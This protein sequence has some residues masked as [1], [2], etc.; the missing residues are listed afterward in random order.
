VRGTLI[1]LR[2]P[3]AAIAIVAV[4]L[5]GVARP[6]RAEEVAASET[7]LPA[8]TRAWLSVPDIRALRQRFD[9]SP[10]GQLLNDPAMAAFVEHVKAEINSNGKQRLA[11]LGLTLEDLEPIPGGEV[12]I[13][14]IESQPGRLAT[15]IL[16]DTTGH[17]A[18]ARELVDRITARLIERKAA[19]VT[20]AGAPPGMSVYRLQPEAADERRGARERR[21]AF[22]QGGSVLVVG[23]DAQQVGQAFS[24]VTTGRK[25]SL[26][27]TA[28][29]MGVMARCTK[30]MPANAAPI[31]WFIDPLPFAK[32]YRESNPPLE[33]R[34]GPD[35][36]EILGRQGFDAIKGLGGVVVFG[37]GGHAVRHASMVWAPP[38][39]GR[40]PLAADSHDL[41]ARML[42]FPN[43]E[44]MVPPDWVPR[45]VTGWSALQWDLRAAFA[46]SET[47]VDDIVGDRG[48]FDDVIASLKEDPDGPQID[49]EKDLVTA[50]GRRV[51]IIT[52]HAEPADPDAE[53]L[54]IAV[55]AVDE[56]RVAATIAKVMG[57]DKDMERK[58]IA[59]HVVWELI[60][61]TTAIPELQ[62][63][64]P[65]LR[66]GADRDD[67]GRR[68]RQ[69]IREKEEKLL[70]HSSVTVAKG[71]LFI[72]SHRD[73]LERVLLT[74]GGIDA[75]GGADDYAVVM[76]EIDR[77]L[78][79]QSA[80]KSF[81]RED[82]TIQPAYELLRRGSMPK[83]QSVFGQ[84]LNALLGDGKPGT[85]REQRIDGATLPEFEVIRRYF[86]TAAVGMEAVADG[87]YVTGL[88][89]PRAT[90]EPE[91][92]RSPDT[93]SIG[94]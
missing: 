13:A 58:E 90:Q 10:Y 50:L 31:R 68:R 65:G 27:A 43:V 63:E 28:P 32:A 14:A 44:R 23:D 17:E 15:V 11:K 5:A 81:G 76:A 53:R 72:A 33:K 6:A 69:R 51:S 52:D 4:A 79:G 22:A 71:H 29:F 12:A 59:G 20:I 86:G 74:P 2:N 49:V 1:A 42:Q 55:E 24:I 60:D 38:L 7:I 19:P 78:P 36:V 37:A 62:V 87:W 26:A 84:L 16:V 91:V 9:R 82:K 89:L 88:S 39:P 94:R 34:K 41:A 67:D 77:L 47:L 8:T 66:L 57:A 40:S 73:V 61:R 45:D 21:V 46:A 54:V 56:P 85:V 48:V 35:Y 30:D 70:P 80:L 25:D 75:L 3:A 93:T 18:E 83:S 92:A 64:T